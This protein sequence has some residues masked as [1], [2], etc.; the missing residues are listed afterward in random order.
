MAQRRGTSTRL[1]FPAEALI[2]I[3]ITLAVALSCGTPAHADDTPRYGY[4]WGNSPYTFQSFQCEM[5]RCVHQEYVSVRLNERVFVQSMDNGQPSHFPGEP[6]PS[7]FPSA[8]WAY[9][10]IRTGAVLLS[11]S[12]PTTGT[13]VPAHIQ[14]RPLTRH[15]GIV[16]YGNAQDPN[17]DK[18]A[19][20]SVTPEGDSAR[21][22]LDA[23]SSGRMIDIVVPKG[24]VVQLDVSRLELGIGV[25]PFQI[26][27]WYEPGFGW[28]WANGSLKFEEYPALWEIF[29]QQLLKVAFKDAAAD[30]H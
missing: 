30:I 23:S 9:P 8:T 20:F 16:A 25:R 22:Q 13:L 12:Q 6:T 17:L 4:S 10:D 2:G 7:E 21:V 29:K 15:F 11:L 14:R 1:R 5:V 3:V 24:R 27:V 18:S 28:V 26:T 19:W